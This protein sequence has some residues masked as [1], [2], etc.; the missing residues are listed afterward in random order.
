VRDA[1]LFALVTIYPT[2]YPQLCTLLSAAWRRLSAGTRR[3]GFPV[4]PSPE[5]VDR[6]LLAVTVLAA[7]LAL[8]Q[9]WFLLV[10]G[11]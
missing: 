1:I 8:W 10:M 7:L 3:F 2:A 6:V 11:L 5:T 9:L 4:A